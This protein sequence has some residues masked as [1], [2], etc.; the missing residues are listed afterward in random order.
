MGNVTRDNQRQK[1]IRHSAITFQDLFKRKDDIVKARHMNLPSF[2]WN[3]L[4]IFRCIQYNDEFLAVHF[5]SFCHKKLM[6]R[7]FWFPW[8]RFAME[9]GIIGL[10]SPQHFRHTCAKCFR[11]WQLR[12]GSYGSHTTHKRFRQHQTVFRYSWFASIEIC[13][14]CL[15]KERE[16]RIAILGKTSSQ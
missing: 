8:E 11:Y 6:H 13:M 16:G 2:K 5:S 9:D 4:C 1:T 7:R 10:Q 15:L 12:K 3:G 14:A